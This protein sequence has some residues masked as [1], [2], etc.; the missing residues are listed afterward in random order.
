MKGTLEKTTRGWVVKETI[1]KGPEAILC[2]TY[3]LHPSDVDTLEP[4]VLGSYGEVEFEII[5]GFDDVFDFPAAFA[6]I[7][8][9]FYEKLERGIDEHM[10]KMAFPNE[11]DMRAYVKQY[12]NEEE[13]RKE[14]AI[15]FAKW[16]AKEWM[17]MWVEDR[18]LWENVSVDTND[19]SMWKGYYTEEELYEIYS[20]SEQ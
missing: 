2:K 3:P 12:E 18:W 14:G 13:L 1:G 9:S 7:S 8:N 11:D 6:K 19:Q 17:S 20:K 4:S 10:I 16:L 5:R 15:D